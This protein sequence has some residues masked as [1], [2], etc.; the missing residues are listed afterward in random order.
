MEARL[1]VVFYLTCFSVWQVV[2]QIWLNSAVI[3]TKLS[4]L[5][6]WLKFWQVRILFLLGVNSSKNTG[7][8]KVKIIPRVQ[9]INSW[10]SL[11]NRSSSKSL[12]FRILSCLDLTFLSKRFLW[13]KVLAIQDTARTDPAVARSLATWQWPSSIWGFMAV[14]LILLTLP[15][16]E[17][18]HQS[19]QAFLFWCLCMGVSA[20]AGRLMLHAMLCFPQLYACKVKTWEVAFNSSSLLSFTNTR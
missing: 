8:I 9:K 18:W 4:D 17:P 16:F 1:F 11:I 14:K 15:T 12:S 5:L 13:M 19:Y 2:L 20:D 7:Y 6:V 10:P 3:L